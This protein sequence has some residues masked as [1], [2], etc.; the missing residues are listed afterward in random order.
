MKL[1]LKWV[2]SKSLSCK[3]SEACGLDSIELYV[4]IV[5]IRERKAKTVQCLLRF[6]TMMSST[7]VGIAVLTGASLLRSVS[8][9]RHLSQPNPKHLSYC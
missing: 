9:Q 5:V 4:H 1:N 3:R 8:D 2:L 6:W 7:S